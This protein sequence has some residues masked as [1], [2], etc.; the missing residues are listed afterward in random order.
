MSEGIAEARILFKQLY[1]EPKVFKSKDYA[2]LKHQFT[3]ARKELAA[4][5]YLCRQQEAREWLEYVLNETFPENQPEVGSDELLKRSYKSDLFPPLRDGKHLCK[6]LNLV[7]PGTVNKIAESTGRPFL[8]LENIN[9]F[10][11]GCRKLGMP[12]HKLFLPLDLLERK[13]MPKVV[14]CIHQFAAL[15]VEKYGIG[16]KIGDRTGKEAFKFDEEELA[17]AGKDLEESESQEKARPT[18]TK[19]DSVRH[20]TPTTTEEDLTEENYQH[21]TQQIL[22]NRKTYVLDQKRPAEVFIEGYSKAEKVSGNRDENYALCADIYFQDGTSIQKKNYQFQTG[23]HDWE[24]GVINL[25]E[26]KPIREIYLY[27]EFE[28]HTGKVWFDRFGVFE[29]NP[30]QSNSS[31]SPFLRFS[32]HPFIR[33]SVSR[34]LTDFSD[35][36]QFV[37]NS[38]F[39]TPDSEKQKGGLVLHWDPEGEGYH[40]E[41]TEAHHGSFSIAVDGKGGKAGA[42]NHVTIFQAEPAKLVIEGRSKAEA[43]DLGSDPDARYAIV[44]EVIYD[45]GSREEVSVDFQPGTHDW[46]KKAFEVDPKGK[47][48]KAVNL[49]A[50]FNGKSG[51]AYFDDFAIYQEEFIQYVKNPSFE[52]VT[53]LIDISSAKAKHWEGEYKVDQDEWCN[54]GHTSVCA[55]NKT[56]TSSTVIYQKVEINQKTPRDLLIEGWSKAEDVSGEKSEDYSVSLEVTFADGTQEKAQPRGEFS[57]GTHDWEQVKFTYSPNKP[58]KTV[59]I[60]AQLKNKFGTAFFDNLTA[61]SEYEFGESEVYI[62]Q[63]LLKSLEEDTDGLDE[64]MDL[65]RRL[66]IELRKTNKMEKELQSIERRIGLL[67]KNRIDVMEVIQA[68]KHFFKIFKRKNQARAGVS[69]GATIGYV[70]QKLALYQNLFYLL[71]TEPKYL[72]KMVTL[73]SP[74]DMDEFLET[75]LLTLF[76]DDFSPREEYLLL[77]VLHNATATEMTSY[78]D[79]AGFLEANTVTAKMIVTYNRRS[80]G[81][82]YLVKILAPVMQRFIQMKDLDLETSPSRA[83]NTLITEEEMQTGQKSK[84]VRVN[85]DEEALAIPEV[86]ELMENRLKTLRET[87][88]SFLDVIIQSVD[89]LPYGLR[90][91]CKQIT[92]IGESHFDVKDKQQLQKTIGYFVYYRFLNPAI[93]SPD[94]YGV[95]R[96]NLNNQQRKNLVQVSKVLQTLFNFSN[97]AG[98]KDKQPLAGLN[99]W[100][101]SYKPTL[102]SYLNKLVSVGEPQDTLG[103]DQ[104]LELTSGTKPVILMTYD[105][106]YATHQILLKHKAQLGAKGDPLLAVLDNLGTLPEYDL[107]DDDAAR[108]VQLNLMN[109]RPDEAAESQLSKNEELS[110][111]AQTRHLF[112]ELL[113][114][115]PDDTS[116]T[117]LYE[118]YHYNAKNPSKDEKRQK[119]VAQIG[120]NLEE[121]EKTTGKDKMSICQKM[122]DDISAYVADK[123]KRKVQRKN[124]IARLKQALDNLYKKQKY[125]EDQMESYTTYLEVARLQQGAKDSKKLKKQNKGKKMS[126]SE[127]KKAGVIVDSSVPEK[128]RKATSFTIARGE[129]PNEFHVKA[130]V[131]GVTADTAVI[132]F[133]ELLEK[134]SQQVQNLELDN[135]TLD[136]NMTVNFINKDHESSFSVSLMQEEDLLSL[137]K[138]RLM[139]YIATNLRQGHVFGIY[140][141]IAKRCH[142]VTALSLSGDH[143]QVFGPHRAV[144]SMTSSRASTDNDATPTSIHFSLILNSIPDLLGPYSTVHSRRPSSI[145]LGNNTPT[146]AGF[147]SSRP[148]SI[149]QRPHSIK[150]MLVLDLQL[151]VSAVIMVQFTY[152]DTTTYIADGPNVVALVAARFQLD[153]NQI[154]VI[155]DGVNAVQLDNNNN[156]RPALAGPYTVFGKITHLLANTVLNFTGSL[157]AA[158][159]A[160]LTAAQ[161]APAGE[162]SQTLARIAAAQRDLVQRMQKLEEV[163]RSTLP[164]NLWSIVTPPD[165]TSEAPVKKSAVEYYGFKNT[166]DRG[167]GGQDNYR[168]T[169]CLITGEYHYSKAVGG[170]AIV[171]AAHL[172]PRSAKDNMRLFGLEQKQINSPRNILLLCQTVEEA[173]DRLMVCFVRDPVHNTYRLKVMDPSLYAEPALPSA[174]SFRVLD[175]KQLLVSTGKMPFHRILS[176]HASLSHRLAAYMDWPTAAGFTPYEELS[177]DE[178]RRSRADPDGTLPA[179]T[180]D[181]VTSLRLA[182]E[183]EHWMGEALTKAKADIQFARLNYGGHEGEVALLLPPLPPP[184]LPLHG[185]GAV[186]KREIGYIVYT[187]RKNQRPLMCFCCGVFSFSSSDPQFLTSALLSCWTFLNSIHS[188]TFISLER[189]KPSDVTLLQD[190]PTT[191]QEQNVKPV[192]SPCGRVPTQNNNTHHYE[193]KLAHLLFLSFT[194][195]LT[196]ANTLVV[197]SVHNDCGSTCTIGSETCCGK[198]STCY[199]SITKRC[200]PKTSAFCGC[201]SQRAFCLG[202]VFNAP[203]TPGD[204][205]FGAC[206]NPSEGTCTYEPAPNYW[207][208]CPLDHQP[209]KSSS[210]FSC[211]APNQV[212]VSDT[213]NSTVPICQDKPL[214]CPQC[215]AQSC[216]NTP[217]DVSCYAPSTHVCSTDDTGAR[218]VCAIGFQAC[219]EA[220]YDNKYYGCNR[221]HL[222]QK[223]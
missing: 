83:Y 218:Q 56:E 136:V 121:L 22:R 114:Q 12:E 19:A 165:E 29:N 220:C 39:E 71:Q 178:E 140:C 32:V 35:L 18:M 186:R 5:A 138:Q 188:S 116:A 172:L 68:Q 79:V 137:D 78:K 155:D 171:K 211:C 21:N 97:F 103:V 195:S 219:G 143:T 15:A 189:I 61:S 57:T 16:R 84:R 150:V 93:V 176:F 92:S 1:K 110:L 85:S 14:Y 88:E 69:Q 9:F 141:D 197:P 13:N 47:P 164:T 50:V 129:N 40:Q 101:D 42:V 52:S 200:C 4:Y 115:I 206:Y 87:A 217:R 125:I 106:V 222:Y 192:S 117:N 3:I 37:Q 2:P 204:D 100:M 149:H 98:E 177:Q 104:Y 209:C 126:Y 212:C 191:P 20:I 181:Y 38:S 213:Y 190:C 113:T 99:A 95:I 153:V 54:T 132:L 86:K 72:A 91:I 17:K 81:Q 152:G 162:A 187:S 62:I 65:K 73:V 184:L 123:A 223:S 26:P 94:L 51:T 36:I 168:K 23:T 102:S 215:G 210:F 158:A 148:L 154:I 142:D 77:Q 202:S 196:L 216:C 80:L 82:E 203:P 221:G 30:A 159:L 169:R 31:V 173:Y 174:R 199:G 67:V 160:T 24:H 11:A 128:M 112:M 161:T 120:A 74:T 64:I 49:R 41:L 122:M 53:N 146:H 170:R 46:E 207:V 163:L 60:K 118:L 151:N 8:M 201:L 63:K 139:V 144:S 127:L 156:G 108:E 145:S 208:V 34:N 96:L 105:E 48:I 194:L 175:G 119:T 7:Q 90:W 131:A 58:V 45:D 107:E 193:M 198:D 89:S 55:D 70:K 59:V 214:T 166:Y 134:Q 167:H 133:D 124:L 28:E 66:L 25:D 6:M 182:A 180:F 33:S 109:P 10:L 76:G 147:E 44:G 27:P 179:P 185:T 157:N 135:V 183:N 205:T 130:K 111:P 75:V 43:V